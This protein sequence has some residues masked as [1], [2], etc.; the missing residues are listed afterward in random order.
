MQCKSVQE[1]LPQYHDHELSLPQR[2]AIRKHLQVC[3]EC[4]AWD[5]MEFQLK[6]ATD[7]WTPELRQHFRQA[8]D[9]C[10]D[11]ALE[12]PAAYLRE[13]AARYGHGRENGARSRYFRL[14]MVLGSTSATLFFF[15][16]VY[17]STLAGVPVGGASPSV[18]EKGPQSSTQSSTQSSPQSGPQSSLQSS[19]QFSQQLGHGGSTGSVSGGG[20]AAQPRGIEAPAE[21][22]AGDTKV[23][24]PEAVVSTATSSAHAPQQTSAYLGASGIHAGPEGREATVSPSPQHLS[25]H[26]GSVRTASKQPPLHTSVFGSALPVQPALSTKGAPPMTMMNLSAPH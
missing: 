16:L 8:S 24:A 5:A 23:T 15:V 14:T 22:A 9:R 18:V 10:L 20:V 13:R 17:Q 21:P 25:T 7:L 11:K 19:Q 26:P 4:R 6:Q 2:C 1:L 3:A 12:D